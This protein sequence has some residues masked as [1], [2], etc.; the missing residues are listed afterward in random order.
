MKKYKCITT[1]KLVKVFVFLVLLILFQGCE[2]L[3]DIN[4]PLS[5]AD[6]KTIYNNNATAISVLS[7][8]YINLS[9][10]SL[11]TGLGSISLYAGLSADEFEAYPT[12]YTTITQAYTN[13]LTSLDAPFWT[14]LYRDIYVSN[15]AIGGLTASTAITAD[16]KNQLLGEAYFMRAFFNFY[17]VNLFGDVP[18]ITT[19]D[20]RI[21]AVATRRPI[22]EVYA[23]IIK[24]LN[25]SKQLINANYVGEDAISSSTERIRPNKSA[26]SALLARVYLYSGNYQLAISE[27]SEVL[28]NTALYNLVSPEN[29]FLANSK[30]AIWQLK[31]VN[32]G[33]NTED[34]KLFILSG[35]PLDDKP[36]SL[37]SDLLSSFEQ[38]DLRKKTW[39]GV[40]SLTGVNIPYSYKYKVNI[41]DA[42]ITEYLMVLRLSEQYLIRSEAYAHLGNK[43]ASLNDL[44]AIR[45]RA[46]LSGL[47]ITNNDDLLSANLKERRVEFFSEW[48]H[49][50]FDLKRLHMIDEVMSKATPLK[51]GGVW[52]PN[53]ALY[54]LP[55]E[56]AIKKSK[57]LVQNPGY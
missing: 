9:Q 14:E 30:E 27:S 56:S 52:N 13:S 21:N 39:I 24:D 38:N 48:G 37:S 2:K 1:L 31:P 10:G 4:P 35:G 12:S 50:W 40:D 28:S 53:F 3:I 47:S 19:T 33:W 7:G 11:A 18:I 44:D 20:Y 29:V 51:G 16:V 54:P 23:Q 55:L 46:G 34:A 32:Q 8:L 36:V 41:Q 6:S 25:L 26:V 43:D 5:S 42:P 17:L 57:Y 15:A 45:H 22:S 49:R